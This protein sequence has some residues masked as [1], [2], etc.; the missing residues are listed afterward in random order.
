MQTPFFP[1]WRAQLYSLRQSRQRLLSQ[2]LPAI[3]K[4]FDGWIAPAALAQESQGLN[5][6][7]RLFPIRLAFW[8][9]LGQILN[10]G[11]SCREA[12][13][14]VLALF[15]LHGRYGTDERTSA[16]CQARQRLP[17][18]RLWK[19]LGQTAA[20]APNPAGCMARSKWWMAA[21]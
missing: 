20:D 6:R 10:P 12:V 15:C 1:C 18:E 2:P 8:S 5:S 9:F 14:Q 16:Y 19:I 17:C 7:E 13:R 11:S 3:Q 21:P 4:L